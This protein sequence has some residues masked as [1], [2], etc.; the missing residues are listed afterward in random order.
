MRGGLNDVSSMIVVNL[1]VFHSEDE[2]EEDDEE[3]ESEDE[4]SNNESV[5]EGVLFAASNS[6]DQPERMMPADKIQFLNWMITDKDEMKIERNYSR[7]NKNCLKKG[8]L[9]ASDI[10]RYMDFLQKRDDE[11]CLKDIKEKPS[12]F[13]DVTFIK[14]DKNCQPHY[15]ESKQL[16]AKRKDF[17][18]GIILRVL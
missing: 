13:Y 8:C 12:L 2:E 9:N 14:F 1:G 18:M 16:K 10:E 3:E 5:E 11:K 17:T 6:P 4:E 15:K 7:I